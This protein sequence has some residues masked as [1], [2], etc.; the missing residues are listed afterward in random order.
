[1]SLWTLVVSKT[2]SLTID[3]NKNKKYLGLDCIVLKMNFIP[4]RWFENWNWIEK[5]LMTALN[6]MDFFRLLILTCCSKLSFLFTLFSQ[7]FLQ[8]IK[9]IFQEKFLTFDFVKS[10]WLIENEFLCKKQ[11]KLKAIWVA[12]N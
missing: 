10:T 12:L 8:L 11:N 9:E 2:D 7:H 6:N 1:M 3:Y 4:C 5:N